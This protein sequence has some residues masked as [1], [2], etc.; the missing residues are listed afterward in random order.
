MKSSF[1]LF[2]PANMS[3]LPSL[4]EKDVQSEDEA[5][6]SASPPVVSL[7]HRP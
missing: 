3:G 5:T 4:R 7:S 6:R 2:M 1:F